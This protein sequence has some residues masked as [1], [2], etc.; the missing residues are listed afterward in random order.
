MNNI[1]F[2][3]PYLMPPP[4][5][6]N[7]R[8]R[9]QFGQITKTNTATSNAVQS[10]RE[11]SFNENVSDELLNQERKVQFVQ[12]E[13]KK[14]SV[15]DISDVKEDGEIENNLPEVFQSKP[16]VSYKLKL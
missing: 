7:N 6:Y 5:L 3:W 1:P 14:I 11:I 13:P 12:E 9:M 16:Q 10:V 15:T 2:C 4:N 8:Q